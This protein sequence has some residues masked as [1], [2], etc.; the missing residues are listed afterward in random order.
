MGFA[1]P[2]TKEEKSV[3]N[4][5]K[6]IDSQKMLKESSQKGRSPDLKGSIGGLNRKNATRNFLK[7]QPNPY[8]L[9]LY[10]D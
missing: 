7:N 9:N 1:K 10:A 5:K 4:I 3:N 2:L 6:M 8:Q